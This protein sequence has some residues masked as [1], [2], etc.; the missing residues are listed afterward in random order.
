[1]ART[2]QVLIVD[3]SPE[4]VDLLR[5]ILESAG[6][7]VRSAA[8]VQAGLMMASAGRFDVIVLDHRF[9]NSPVVGISTVN[10]F[11]KWATAGVIMLTAFGD[12]ELEKDAKLLGAKAYLRKPVPA[13][14]MLRTI[15]QILLGT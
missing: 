7:K 5:R 6:H 9:D 2:A 14:T 8:D 10:E 12:A 1:M 13:D 11:A 15:E 3:D 4:D